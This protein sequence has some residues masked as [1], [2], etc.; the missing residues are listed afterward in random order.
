MEQQVKLKPYH[1][2]FDTFANELRWRILEN[3]KEQPMSVNE[4][5]EKTG[6]ERSNVSHNL[7]MLRLC[8]II[9]SRQDGKNNIYFIKD[10]VIL[11]NV[12]S[13]PA[14]KA[15]DN[16]IETFCTYCHK[17]KKNLTINIQ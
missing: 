6:A 12:E 10:A 4:L 13:G 17:I 1:E 3:L 15:F 16:H 9:E 11:Q 5:A 8:S 14:L 2:C 7:Q